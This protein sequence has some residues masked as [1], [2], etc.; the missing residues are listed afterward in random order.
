MSQRGHSPLPWSLR[1][2]GEIVDANGVTIEPFWNSYDA[3]LIVRAVNAHGDLVAACQA[4]PL[5][6]SFEDATDFKDNA[7]AFRL[8]M[9]LAR[10]AIAKATGQEPQS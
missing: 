7:N 2:V 3:E 5:D 10:A 1:P 6:S 8:A 9:I 4:L